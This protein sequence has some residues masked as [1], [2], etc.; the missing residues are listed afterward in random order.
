LIFDE[1]SGIDAKVWE[2]ALGALTDEE[3]EIISSPSATR[4]RHG[5]FPHPVRPASRAVEYGADRQPDG[6]GDN[7]AY[8]DELV[9]TYGI[10]SDIVKVRVLGQFPSASSMQF[11]DRRAWPRRGRGCRAGRSAPIR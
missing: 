1:A 9:D 2:V 7:K 11:I 8:L 10:D 6:G 3:T 5:R 4:P